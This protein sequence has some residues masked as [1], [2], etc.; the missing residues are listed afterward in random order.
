MADAKGILECSR[1]GDELLAGD[2]YDRCDEC[3]DVYCRS[4]FNDGK[5]EVD[6]LADSWSTGV[7]CREC[8]ESRVDYKVESQNMRESLPTFDDE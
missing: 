1:C 3:K 7:I 4:C 8:V 5:Q 6:D 2:A